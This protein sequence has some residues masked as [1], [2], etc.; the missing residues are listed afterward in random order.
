MLKK[1]N[2]IGA[3]V[4]DFSIITV[5]FNIIYSILFAVFGFYLSFKFGGQP[6]ELVLDIFRALFIL[7]LLIFIAAT[8]ELLL[9]SK[10]G[11]TFG[12]MVLRVHVVDKK[13]T[14]KKMVEISKSN[15]FKRELYK[16]TLI[17]ATFYLYAFYVIISIVINKHNFYYEKVSHSKVE[18]W[19]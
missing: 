11:N 1:W 4:I 2:R 10:I 15:F 19:V 7:F 8:Y 9:F 16:W 5:L 18:V 13:S 14:P 3:S 17:I 12:R 6:Y